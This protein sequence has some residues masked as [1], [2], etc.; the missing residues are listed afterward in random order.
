MLLSLALGVGMTACAKKQTAKVTPPPPAPQAPTATIAAEPPVITSGQ[1]TTISWQ[2]DN[3]TDVTIAGLG[4]VPASGSRTV[5]PSD[6]TTYALVAKGPGGTREASARVTVNQLVPA[7]AAVTTNNSDLFG[8]RVK[9]VFFDYDKYDIRGDQEPIT[10]ADA[11]YLREHPEVSIVLEGHCDD[12]GSDEYNLALG[13]SRA[14]AVKDAL[15]KMGV[16]P[17][18][19]KTVSY[20]KERPFCNEDS[21]ACWQQNRRGHIVNAKASQTVAEN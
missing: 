17:K 2:T 19:I 8:R 4:T 13:D 1:S 3:A 9:D 5:S 16:N 11:E 10:K 15:V 21:E 12:R 7:S 14:N 6:S 20:G 18:Q